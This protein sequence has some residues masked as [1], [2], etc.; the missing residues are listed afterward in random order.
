[1]E[2]PP[3]AQEKP[4]VVNKTKKKDK[5]PNL[6]DIGLYLFAVIAGGAIGWMLILITDPTMGCF[7][8]RV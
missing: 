3:D 5:K 4:Q 8:Q 7:Y 2:N 1:M 6:R